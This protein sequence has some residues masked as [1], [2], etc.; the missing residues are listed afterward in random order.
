MLLNLCGWNRSESSHFR[1][2]IHVRSRTPHHL[3]RPIISR[4]I[5]AFW[6]P[7]GAPGWLDADDHS[8]IQTLFTS[9]GQSL[10]HELFR[11]KP[12]LSV[13]SHLTQG[14][15]QTYL[16]MKQLTLGLPVKCTSTIWPTRETSAA[17]K[18]GI[19]VRESS[20]PWKL[21][22]CTKMLQLRALHLPQVHA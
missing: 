15:P 20:S 7:F 12:E 18:C 21:M 4:I 11:G 13:R 5:L 1:R 3:G 8:P 2:L 9:Q 6:L 10:L 16:T 19:M 17:F 14:C 22:T